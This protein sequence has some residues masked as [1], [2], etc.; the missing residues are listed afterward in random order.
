MNGCFERIEIDGSAALR[1]CDDLLDSGDCTLP[2]PLCLFVSFF[3]LF[4]G[5]DRD[6]GIYRYPKKP[7]S[8]YFAIL[9]HFVC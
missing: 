3:L 5:G 7:Q 2:H 6:G 4:F 8:V 1:E 9:Q